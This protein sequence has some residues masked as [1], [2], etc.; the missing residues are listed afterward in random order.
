MYS[1]SY[2]QQI[3]TEVIKDVMAIS[4]HREPH[5][6]AG[7]GIMHAIGTGGESFWKQVALYVRLTAY[8]AALSVLHHILS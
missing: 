1:L 2:L 8:E 3:I 5:L 6:T 4:P 7:S